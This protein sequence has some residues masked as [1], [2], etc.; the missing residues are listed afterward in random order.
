MLSAMQDNARQGFGGRRKH[1]R[2]FL[3]HRP[4]GI[5]V[6]RPNMPRFGDWYVREGWYIYP[7]DRSLLSRR[8]VCWGMAGT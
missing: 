5:E 8:L 4:G 6:T 1:Q 3:G 2:P 7:T